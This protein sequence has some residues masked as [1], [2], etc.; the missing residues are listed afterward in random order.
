MAIPWSRLSPGALIRAVLIPL[1]VGWTVAGLVGLWLA[2]LQQNELTNIPNGDVNALLH[3][4]LGQ[5]LVLIFVPAGIVAGLLVWLVN[6]T[7]A[8]SPRL[9]GTVAG[10]LIALVQ[11]I[12]AVGVLHV[13]WI[14][15]PLIGILFVGAGFY[16]GWGSNKP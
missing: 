16:A 10:S 9:L 8:E 15:V 1:I 11:G 6:R 14:Y 13:P 5:G 3:Y 2:Q 12:I 7:E 4:E